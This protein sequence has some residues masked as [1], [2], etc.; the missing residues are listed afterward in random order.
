MGDAWP[1]PVNATRIH[2][3]RCAVSQWPPLRAITNLK[4]EIASNELTFIWFNNLAFVEGRREI[5][6]LNP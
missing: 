3:A 2:D 4:K 5:S 1:L 6:S